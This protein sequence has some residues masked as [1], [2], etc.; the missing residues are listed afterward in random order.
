MAVT[1]ESLRRGEDFSELLIALLESPVGSCEKCILY[2][3]W[4]SDLIM[5]LCWIC[6]FQAY[7]PQQA[8]TTA[9]VGRSLNST[10]TSAT[11]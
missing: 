10:P 7:L 1:F 5:Q 9:K 3:G 11:G 6:G 2:E 4:A 8:L